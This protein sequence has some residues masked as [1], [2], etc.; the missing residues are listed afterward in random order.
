MREKILCFA[1]HLQSVVQAVE[2]KDKNGL[3]EL[4]TW[5]E[6]CIKNYAQSEVIKVT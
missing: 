6:L 1:L 5:Y 3:R 4:T 2:E